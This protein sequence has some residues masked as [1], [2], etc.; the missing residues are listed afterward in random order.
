MH[1]FEL[2]AGLYLGWAGAC[3]SLLGG[4]L[5]CCACKEVSASQS[6]GAYYAA[7]QGQKIHKPVSD[8][9]TARAYV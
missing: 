6:K 1:W 4:G 5:L 3:L 8:T 2:G 9:E 7:N